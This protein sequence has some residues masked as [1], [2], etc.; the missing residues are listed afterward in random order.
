MRRVGLLGGMGPEA[1]ILI[2]QR[3]LASVTASDD[4]D[5]IP[6]LVDQ[7]TQVPS[8]LEHLVNGTGDDPAPVLA[9]MAR[10]LVVSGAEALAMPCNTAHFYG[11]VIKAAVDVPFLD[12]IQ[13]SVNHAAQLAGSEKVVGILASP[14]VKKI[15]LF[16][17][18]LTKVGLRPVFADDDGAMQQA[19][20]QIKANGRGAEARQVLKSASEEFYRLEAALVSLGYDICCLPKASIK[21]RADFVLDNLAS[22]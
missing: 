16:E 2:M 1:T 8:R 19:I 17:A 13:L 11:S 6:L 14:A 4:K 7:N 9:D 21:E 3:I 5:H 20:Q 10:R 22:M 15:G 12:M 18:E